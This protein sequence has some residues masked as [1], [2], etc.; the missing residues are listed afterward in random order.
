MWMKLE[1]IYFGL[2]K[3]IYL[4]AQC[5]APKNSPLY[6]V[7]EDLN[8]RV[9]LHQEIHYDIDIYSHEYLAQST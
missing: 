5:I 3:D 6:T 8:N 2:F 4:C 9:G 7:S 1:K